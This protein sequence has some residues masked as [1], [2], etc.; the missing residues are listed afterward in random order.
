VTAEEAYFD[1]RLPTAIGGTVLVGAYLYGTSQT[2]MCVDYKT[3][4]IK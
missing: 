4:Q 1:P 2:M 3:G